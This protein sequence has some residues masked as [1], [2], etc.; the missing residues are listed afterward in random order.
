M[1]KDRNKRTFQDEVEEI[2][3]SYGVYA[4]KKEDR[5]SEWELLRKQALK[6]NGKFHKSLA[7]GRSYFTFSYHGLD[8]KS[9]IKLINDFN[10]P[11]TYIKIKLHLQNKFKLSLYFK[12]Y[13]PFYHAQQYG[14]ESYPNPK[15]I[16]F[17]IGLKRIETDNANFNEKF[18]VKGNDESGTISLLKHDIKNDLLDLENDNFLP[19]IIINKNKFLLMTLNRTY[20]EDDYDKIINLAIKFIDQLKYQGQINLNSD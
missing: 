14:I 16:Q 6:R 1:E 13:S 7:I 20:S 17:L 15:F 3:W 12:D 9:G 2:A 8:I 5:D 18:I 11:A 10:Q 4:P 19:I